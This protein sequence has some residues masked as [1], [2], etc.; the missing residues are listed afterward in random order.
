MKRNLL[1]EWR[2]RALDF[3]EEATAESRAIGPAWRRLRTAAQF[4]WLVW[5]GFSVNRCPLRAAALCYTTLL[6]LVPLLAV[7]ISVSKSFLRE[8]SAVVV[9]QMLDALVA[10]IAPQLEYLPAADATNTVAAA[11][12]VKVSD[13]ARQQVVE[14][15]QSFIGNIDAGALGAIGTVALVIVAI[16]LLMTI[17]QT[18]NDIWGVATGRSIWRKVVYYWA[19][20]TLGPVVLVTAIALTGRAE[21]AHALHTVAAIPGAQRFVLALVPYLVLWAGFALLYALMPNTAVRW[22]A[23]LAGGFVGGTLWQLNSLLNTMYFSRVVT[24]SKIYGGLGVIPV[25]LLGLYLSWLIVLFGAQVAYAAQHVRTFIGQRAM[26]RVDQAGRER[27]AVRIVL[28]ACQSFLRGAPAPT[29]AHLADQLAAP[30]QLLNRL[31]PRLMSAGILSEVA[32]PQIALAPA[33]PPAAITI[34]DVLHAMRHETGN[35]GGSEPVDEL[36][37]SLDADLR[38]SSANRNFSELAG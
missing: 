34:A 31:I 22:P 26:E 9:P 37:T 30:P 35:H 10:R 29:I 17:E 27:L 7:G 18:F 19:A 8:S 2:Q 32:E 38:A 13:A 15:I 25:F 1:T 4:I 3:L 23:A 21:V 36:L 20:V 14:Q 12:Q 5:R 24:Y 33:R 11:G 6:A 28:L 16:R